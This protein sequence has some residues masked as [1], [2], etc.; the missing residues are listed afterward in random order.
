MHTQYALHNKKPFVSWRMP[1]EEDVYTITGTPDVIHNGFTSRRGFLIA[2][3]TFSRQKEAWFFPARQVYKNVALSEWASPAQNPEAARSSHELVYASRALYMKQF[4]TL[5][6]QFAGSTLSK[7]VLSRIIHDHRITIQDAIPLYREMLKQYPRAMVY[8]ACLPDGSC[9]MGASPELLLRVNGAMAYTT[10]VAATQ[11]G[12][13]TDSHAWNQ[14]EK[15]EQQIVTDYI[16][17]LLQKYGVEGVETQGP[18]TYQAGNVWHLRTNFAFP[19][20]YLHTHTD[21]FLTELHPTPAVC[22][23]PKQQAY[24]VLMQTEPHDREFYA[25]FLGPVGISNK[26]DL[27][28]NLRS[29]QLFHDGAA[30]Y[31]GGGIT[32]ESQPEAE[33]RETRQKAATMQNVIKTVKAESCIPIKKA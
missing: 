19:A 11:S 32:P 7:A 25:G 15:T 5:Q 10:S 21:Q 22:G 16:Y 27:F 8:L 20:H 26:L 17:A 4:E 13:R 6:R 24:E 3:Y 9:W 30:L 18:K 28:V 23:T 29:M 31:A 1:G 2:P 33:W 14:K 12:K